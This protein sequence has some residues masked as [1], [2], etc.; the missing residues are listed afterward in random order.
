MARKKLYV[1]PD[2]V[3]EVV[4]MPKYIRVINRHGRQVD[5]RSDVYK[6]QKEQGVQLEW[7]D[8]PKHVSLQK[9]LDAEKEKEM[10]ALRAEIEAL[11]AREKAEKLEE[12]ASQ[13]AKQSLPEAPAQEDADDESSEPAPK[14]SRNKRSSKSKDKDISVDLG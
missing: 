7:I 5:M 2:E 1:T 14:N 11:K 4:Q 10:E 13:K 6:K 9:I 12:E 8:D 3:Q